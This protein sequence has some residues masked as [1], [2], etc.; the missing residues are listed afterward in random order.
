M[1]ATQ[2]LIPQYTQ[3]KYIPRPKDRIWEIDFIRGICVILMILDHLSLLIAGYFAVSWYGYGYYKLGLGDEFSRFCY[4]WFFLADA[5]PII[6]NIVLLFFF[7]I[8]GISCTLSRSNSK[9]GAQLMIVAII[10]TI[11]TAIGEFGLGINDIFTTFGVLDFLATCMLLYA[12][13]SWACRRDVY[14]T[15]IVAVGIIGITLILYFCYTPPAS[16]PKIFGILFPTYD[17]HGNKSLF[18]EQ[19]DIS[20][21]DLFT[22]IPYTAYYFFGVLIG[23]FLYGNRRSLLPKLYGKWSAPVRFVGRHALIVYV[24]HVALMALILAII[25][26]LFITPG[27]FGF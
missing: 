3:A 12:F 17:V 25:S 23:P 9:R 18:Y 14:A 1:Q 10:Y 11:C 21:G 27:Q 19:N 22:L 15:S 8:S 7:G 6:H 5:R 4:Y 24:V 26:Y 20:P 13:I 2:I 16:T